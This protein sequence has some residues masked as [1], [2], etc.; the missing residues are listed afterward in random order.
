LSRLESIIFP[1]FRN[2][3]KTIFLAILDKDKQAENIGQT[4]AGLAF[5]S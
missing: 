5:F 2:I 3:E 1:F 4:Q